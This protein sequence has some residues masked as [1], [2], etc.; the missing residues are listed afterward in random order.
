MTLTYSIAPNSTFALGPTT[1]T[2][3]A[4]DGAKQPL[5]ATF[6][7]HGQGH[8]AP[9]ISSVSNLTIEATSA[10]GAAVTFPTITATDAVG[11]VTITYSQGSG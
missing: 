7:G 8:D 9:A 3:T 11:A 2:V 6:T 5:A 10:A 4:T 1:V